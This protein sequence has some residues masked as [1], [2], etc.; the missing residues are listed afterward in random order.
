MITFSI[1]TLPLSKNII[2]SND[3]SSKIIYSATSDT[4]FKYS[5]KKNKIIKNSCSYYKYSNN[6]KILTIKIRDDLY[7]YNGDKVTA[8]DYYHTFRHILNSK[9]H[10]GIIFRHFFTDIKILDDC[11]FQLVNKTKN[12]KSY[13][14]LSIYSACCLKNNYTSG[15]YYIEKTV[16]NFIILKRNEF[17]REKIHNKDAEVIK[18]IL[19][20]GLN[21]YKLFNNK[22]I[23]IT[24]NTMCDINNIDKYNYIRENN[25]IYLNII[26][27][28][29]MMRNRYKKIRKIISDIIDKDKIANMLDNKY[30]INESFIVN[31][32]ITNIKR[33]KININID[34]TKSIKPL[35]L[36][37][38]N[39]Y[40]NKIIA[41]EIKKQLEA[42][43]FKIDLV[44]NKFNIKNTCDLNIT[45]NHLEYITESSIIN[46]SYFFVILEKNSIYKTILKMYNVTHKKYLL[47]L[48]NKKLL[49]LKYKIPLLK[50]NGYYLKSD[51]Y[52]KFNYIEL[53]FNEM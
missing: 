17:Y 31:N 3:Y 37:Y 16:K 2:D 24:N 46:G 40:P 29:E 39:F 22:I 5:L 50:M 15:A 7:F 34:T 11:T 10:I 6:N 48:I 30:D 18:F 49:K 43:G 36:G 28:N 4:L 26:F 47:D 51:K 33:K 23:Q 25:Y 32:S 9:T 35:T 8:N 52:N 42:V 14:I 27:S 21:D 41:E 20:D 45:L 19:T 53:N 1:D 44:E 13:E 12:D 38:N